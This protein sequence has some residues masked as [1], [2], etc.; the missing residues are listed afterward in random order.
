MLIQATKFVEAHAAKAMFNE[1][2]ATEVPQVARGHAAI[3]GNTQTP[4]RRMCKTCRQQIEATGS[5]T[6]VNCAACRMEARVKKKAAR[7]PNVED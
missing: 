5:L 3:S 1:Q 2:A 4:S 6:H 7:K